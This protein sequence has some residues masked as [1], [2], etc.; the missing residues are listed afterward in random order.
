MIVGATSHAAFTGLVTT[1]G[2]TGGAAGLTATITTG[3]F[4]GDTITIANLRDPPGPD[5]LPDHRPDPGHRHHHPD[6]HQPGLTEP[7][8]QPTDGTTAPRQ[9]TRHHAPPLPGPGATMILRRWRAIAT[10][11]ALLGTA[12]AA[13]ASTAHAT[14]TVTCTG[15]SAIAYQP[16][17]TSTPRT[18]HYDE[19][20]TYNSCTSTDH[21][22]T[23]GIAFLALDFPDATCNG[24]AGTFTYPAYPI[25]WDNGQTSTLSLTFTDLI[26][27]GV[28]QS[29]GV[30]TVTSGRFPGATATVTLNLTAP[31]PLQCLTPHGVTSQTGIATLTITQP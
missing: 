22:P 1:L 11:T 17:L 27:S 5:R 8:A 18:V 29:T 2:S 12:A 13:D 21:T 23:S 6:L 24:L 20:D 15:T 16:G 31:D 14:T 30:G 28:E 25:V 9:P 4:T 19:T 26:A 7:H 10:A 3:R